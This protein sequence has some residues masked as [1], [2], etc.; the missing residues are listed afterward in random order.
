M[1]RLPG[2]PPSSENFL[3][4]AQA[5]ANVGDVSGAEKILRLI[6]KTSGVFVDAAR[7]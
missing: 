4:E 3:A 2:L 7:L 6:P 1:A 5:R